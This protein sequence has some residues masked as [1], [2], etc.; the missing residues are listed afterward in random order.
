MLPG[1]IVPTV[2][3]SWRMFNFRMAV[4][5]QAYAFVHRE[6]SPECV[7]EDYLGHLY[8]WP[9]VGYPQGPGRNSVGNGKYLQFV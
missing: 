3:Q 4:Q 8:Q 6:A 9:L 1:Y 5:I 7:T 2:Q